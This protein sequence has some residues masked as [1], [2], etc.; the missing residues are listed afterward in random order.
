MIS[1][2][3]IFILWKQYIAATLAGFYTC[4]IDP[5][6][7]KLS[8][9]VFCCWTA[10]DEMAAVR[11]GWARW[12]FTCIRAACVATGLWTASCWNTEDEYAQQ[13][14][15]ISVWSCTLFIPLSLL[16]MPTLIIHAY[17]A[18][19]FFIFHGL[20][21]LAFS[22]QLLSSLGLLCLYEY[23]MAANGKYMAWAH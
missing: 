11:S 21:W 16:V 4:H 18:F 9:V 10:A 5:D 17:Y 12:R 2:L 6:G 3:S 1:W 20:G 7:N 13:G 8:C 15:H 19:I 14:I 23:L 22:H